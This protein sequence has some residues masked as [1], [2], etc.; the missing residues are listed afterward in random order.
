MPAA[1]RRDSRAAILT[2]ALTLHAERG[3]ATMDEIRRR[4]GVSNGS[5]FH[6]FP[7]RAA[8][9]AAL[10][11]DVLDDYHAA[12]RAALARA[13][14]AEAGVRAM[15]GAHLRWVEA[16]PDAA[17]WLAEKRD[18]TSGA[19]ASAALA[20]R[21]EAVFAELRAW[22]DRHV[23]AGALRAVSLEVLIAVVI[24]PAQEVT[25]QWLRDAQPARLRRL[26]APLAE[27]AWRAVRSDNQEST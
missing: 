13:T 23:A 19:A 18:A 1:E 14:S 24:G 25:H 26:V 8:L 15:V 20:E 7:D 22:R 12:I 21:N 27:A 17:R 6:H 5:L 10:Y 4:A 11:L 16:R 9:A 3:D 2:A